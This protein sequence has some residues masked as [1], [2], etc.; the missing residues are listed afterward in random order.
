[1]PVEEEGEEYPVDGHGECV[2]M[3]SLSEPGSL[4]ES[5]CSSVCSNASERRYICP[6]EQEPNN[7]QRSK[8]VPGVYTLNT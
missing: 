4:A 5:E 3:L 1:M 6:S 8:M 2:E 7:E